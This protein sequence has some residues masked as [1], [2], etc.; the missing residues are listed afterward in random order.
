MLLLLCKKV[1]KESPQSLGIGYLQIHFFH[2]FETFIQNNKHLV[3]N[4]PINTVSSPK[5]LIIEFVEN[6]LFAS[7]GAEQIAY[8]LLHW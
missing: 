6:S 8:K 2:I 7:N 5:E 1:E 4:P 3:L